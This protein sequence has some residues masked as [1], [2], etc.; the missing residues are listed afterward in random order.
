MLIILVA[1][2]ITVGLVIG[3]LMYCNYRENEQVDWKEKYIEQMK[4][5]KELIDEVIKTNE[6]L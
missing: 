4:I 1:I 2:L 5:N 3:A 6:E